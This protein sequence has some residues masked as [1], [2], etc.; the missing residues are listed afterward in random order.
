MGVDLFKTLLI[1][2]KCYLL[3]IITFI[4]YYSEEVEL[5][6]L[7]NTSMHILVKFFVTLS[8]AIDREVGYLYCS[9][10]WA[11]LK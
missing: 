6:K 11:G 5:A 10:N 2:I 3:A 8:S 1:S 4:T 9:K 7:Y